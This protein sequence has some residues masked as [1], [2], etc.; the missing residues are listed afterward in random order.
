[1]VAVVDGLALQAALR[2]K[3]LDA[4]RALKVLGFFLEQSLD[5]FVDSISDSGRD[6]AGPPGP[7]AAGRTW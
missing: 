1:M 2:P 5:A 6:T 7:E 4:P 3:G